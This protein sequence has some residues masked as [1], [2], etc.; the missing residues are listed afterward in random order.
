LLK[1]RLS[2]KISRL[3]KKKVFIYL[4]SL[5]MIDFLATGDCPGGCNGHGQ[6]VNNVCTCQNGWAGDDCSFQLTVL[7]PNVSL[8]DQR[9]TKYEWHFYS[10][11]TNGGSLL[12]FMD[13]T[14][15]KGDTDLY[16]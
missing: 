6:C 3:F 1:T 9:I 14:S 15:D 5:F 12:V 8:R 4:F 13:Q 11:Q 7:Q 2:S 10:I 16:I